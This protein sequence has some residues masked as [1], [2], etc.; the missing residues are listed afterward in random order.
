[1]DVLGSAGLVLRNLSLTQNNFSRDVRTLATGLR[2]NSA[3]DDPSGLAIADT[4][5]SKVMGLQQSVTNV[6]TGGNLLNVADGAL[7]TVTS[8][9]QRIRSLV[10]QAHSDINS[11]DQLNNIQTEINQLL[12]EINKISSTVSFNGLKLF[13]GAFDTS[14]GTTDGITQVPSPTLAA[15]GSS[16]SPNVVN[17]DGLG[18]PGL[19]ISNAGPSGMGNAIPALMVFQVL[20]YSDNAVDPDTGTP[21]GPGV[22]VQFSAYSQSSGF[23]A[24]PLM[25]DT[26]AVPIN[27]GPIMSTFATP[28]G[29]SNLLEFTLANLTQADVGATIA[30]QTTNGTA[31]ATGT[32][33]TINDGGSEGT[34]VSVSLPTLSTNALNISGISVLPPNVVNFINQLQGPSSSNNL[35]V[36]SSE[37][38]VDAALQQVNDARA[39]IG[40]QAVALQQDASNSG[41][42]IV[43]YTAT[44]SN[45]RDANIGQATTDF[46][47]NQILNQVGTSVLAQLRV[48]AE[49]LSAL[50]FS[51]TGSS[52]VHG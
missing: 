43:N 51:A 44:E 4:F 52:H 45:I 24:A 26:S 40:A 23:G 13:D 46:A 34:T 37:I 12:L 48:S 29:S 41:V 17:A 15:D 42:A 16:G 38:A 22:Y 19:L 10:V 36:A 6:Q 11:L 3:V 50:L 30:F 7:S 18:N 25:V 35:A 39:Q 9:L 14:Q 49:Q 21:V 20:S 31:A 47:R 32:P 2:V 8:I 33:L 28:N 1:M 5:Q 27:A